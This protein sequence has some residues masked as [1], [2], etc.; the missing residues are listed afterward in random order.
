MTNVFPKDVIMAAEAAQRKWLVPSSV[1]LAQWALESDYGKREPAGSNNPFGI[2][3]T[4]G[5]AFVEANTHEVV[6]GQ[7]IPVVA[8]FAKFAN[9]DEAFDAHGKLLATHSAY[10]TAMEKRMNAD[11]FANALT[12]HYAT[13]PAYG[14]K[15]I[16][17]MKDYGL[18]GYDTQAQLPAVAIAPSPVAPPEPAAPQSA[19]AIKS[20]PAPVVTLPAEPQHEPL[21]PAQPET[22]PKTPAVAEEANLTAS[23]D[24]AIADLTSIKQQLRQIFETLKGLVGE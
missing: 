12:G 19:S 6:N 4:A 11:D 13:D 8:K 21:A 10:K 24:Q 9:L 7:S 23:L 3:A 5:E 22:L 16:T 17:I 2:K 18:Y 14:S 1:T 15:L 20:D